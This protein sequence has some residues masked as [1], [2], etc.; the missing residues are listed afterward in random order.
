MPDDIKRTGDGQIEKPATTSGSESQDQTV[1]AHQTPADSQ[2]ASPP[3]APQ[4]AGHKPPPPVKKGPVTTVEITGD[5]LIDQLKQKF[6]P[7]IVEAVAILGQQVLRVT[8]DSLLDICNH[9]RT[10][11]QYRFDLCAD[12]T[13]VHWPGR[14]LGAFDVVINLFSI[15][16]RQGLRLK[17]ALAEGEA[18]P[19]LSAI[20][21][22]ASWME[23]EVYDMFGI[24]FDG[25][26][27][28]RR[29]LLPE[30]WPGHP[31]RKEYPIEYRDN[32]WTDKHLEYR[33][34]E[35]DTSL[36]NVK[37]AERR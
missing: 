24:V 2:K 27:D 16:R 5:P 18:C 7:S 17:T 1:P 6:G 33:E 11:D 13:A 3:K 15:P 10:D 22:G 29:I 23:R 32:E 28:L 12:V 26:P 19:S 9:L 20:W 4:T 25:H 8:K 37:Y 14:D 35:Y 21:T 36:I 30:D 34:I 31:L